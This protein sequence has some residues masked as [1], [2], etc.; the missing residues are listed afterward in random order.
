MKRRPS[1][2][3]WASANWS[4][5]LVVRPYTGARSGKWDQEELEPS[6]DD[7]PLDGLLLRYA[8]SIVIDTLRIRST[9]TGARH[10]S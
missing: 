1:H 4:A 8:H 3:H 6:R 7:H 9:A 2:E 10:P 5:S